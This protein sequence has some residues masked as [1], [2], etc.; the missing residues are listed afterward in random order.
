M[1]F[2]LLCYF[3]KTLY[4]ILISAFGM[5]HQTEG[6]VFNSPVSVS[7]IS[8]TLISQCVQR[9]VTKKAIKILRIGIAM[10]RIIFA[11][12]IC[13]KRMVVFLIRHSKLFLLYL[14]SLMVPVSDHV[15]A[16]R[17]IQR[18]DSHHL[19]GFFPIIQC[20]QTFSLRIGENR[21]ISALLCGTA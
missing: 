13:E 16:G 17:L 11:F 2:D 4:N 9:T 14:L 3:R 7:K 18:G 5:W 1:S 20:I 19:I 15:S 21:R 8:S 10:T 12:E 6:T